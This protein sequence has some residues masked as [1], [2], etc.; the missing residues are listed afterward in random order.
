MIFTIEPMI[1]QGVAEAVI[2]SNDKW[3]A[4]TADGKLSAQ[5]EHTVL[6]TEFGVEVLTK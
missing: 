5:F 2:D 4:R 1:N 3:K 6:V